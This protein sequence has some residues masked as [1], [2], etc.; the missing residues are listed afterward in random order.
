MALLHVFSF[1]S[2]PFVALVNSTDHVRTL[3]IVLHGSFLAVQRIHLQGNRP[4]VCTML[5][6]FVLRL[7]LLV[8]GFTRINTHTPYEIDIAVQHNCEQYHFTSRHAP[9]FTAKT[10]GDTCAICISSLML[11]NYRYNSIS[12]RRI[13]LS[14]GSS[15]IFTNFTRS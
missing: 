11:S 13:A 4:W 15:A 12:M 1:L 10:L 14:T 3:P 2:F 9:V 6:R 7:V 5:L 8:T